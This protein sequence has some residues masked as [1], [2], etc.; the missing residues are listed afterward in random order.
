VNLEGGKYTF[1]VSASGVLMCDRLGQPWRS[2]LGDKA[3]AA[4]YDRVLELEAANNLL[5][6]E[7]MQ[8]RHRMEG[9]AV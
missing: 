6:D 3:V 1:H 8:L 4:L 9:L 7:L 2:F 5:E